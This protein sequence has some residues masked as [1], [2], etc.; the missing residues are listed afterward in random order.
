MSPKYRLASS[1]LLCVIFNVSVSGIMTKSVAAE[2]PKNAKSLIDAYERDT[3]ATQKKLSKETLEWRSNV[4]AKLKALQQNLAADEK[5]EE[6][7]SVRDL[8][9]TFETGKS[10][11]ATG[12]TS[13]QKAAAPRTI[14]QSVNTQRDVDFTQPLPKE[15]IAALPREAQLILIEN[16]YPG[17]EVTRLESAMQ[18]KSSTLR[19]KLAELQSTHTKKG[20][21]DEAVAIRD[22]V[23]AHLKADSE[24][25]APAEVGEPPRKDIALGAKN[26]A[27]IQANYRGAV[28]DAVSW[29][30]RVEEEPFNRLLENLKSV[31]SMLSKSGQLEE[32]LIVRDLLRNADSHRGLRKVDFVRQAQPSVPKDAQK[33]IDDFF[34][35]V[36]PFADKYDAIISDLNTQMQKPA[37]DEA[38]KMLIAGDM[39]NARRALLELYARMNEQFPYLQSHLREPLTVPREAQELLDRFMDENQERLD[40]VDEKEA[41]LREALL[42]KLREARKR[43]LK[44]REEIALDTTIAYLENE[45]N[46]GVRGLILFR[47]SEE[48]TGDLAEMV[49]EFTRKLHGEFVELQEQHQLAFEEMQPKFNDIRKAQAEAEDW[50]AAFSTICLQQQA[51]RLFDPVPIMFYRFPHSSRGYEALMVGVRNGIFRVRD[52]HQRESWGIREEI[53]VGDEPAPDPEFKNR[54]VPGVAVTQRTKLLPGQLAMTQSS[55]TYEILEILEPGPEKVRVRYPDSFQRETVV[56]RTELRIIPDE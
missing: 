40:A 39:E 46:Q 49:D 5:L 36:K 14:R 53:R 45:Y 15:V 29:L 34:T 4:T 41:P 17:D 44:A 30:A 25:S 13:Q 12:L 54:P 1:V 51:P 43:N 37:K 23:R 27:E 26:N 33:L 28:Q 21:L 16:E 6:A 50:K 48:L 8:V 18:E 11:P 35:E 20:E 32:A 10:L 31:Q 38:K 24:N 47:R 2:L 19:A 55:F 22:W 9:R 56:D 52:Q 42:E 3:A 7:I